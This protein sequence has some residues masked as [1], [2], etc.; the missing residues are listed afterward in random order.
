MKGFALLPVNAVSRCKDSCWS[1]DGSS[2]KVSSIVSYRHLVF[3]LALARRTTT[4]YAM[5]GWQCKCIAYDNQHQYD[6]KYRMKQ[7]LRTKHLYKL[8]A[9]PSA[10]TYCEHEYLYSETV[11]FGNFYQR[12]TSS[13][14][15]SINGLKVTT[16]FGNHEPQGSWF[17]CFAPKINLKILELLR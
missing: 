15:L 2:A 8:P 13:C 6:H 1:D 4:H 14:F 5:F 17:T 9:S 7:K 16:Y 11:K 10:S 3:E 12:S